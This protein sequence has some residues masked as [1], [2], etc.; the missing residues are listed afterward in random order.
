MIKNRIFQQTKS[1]SSSFF[2]SVFLFLSESR[3]PIFKRFS[4]SDSEDKSP[5]KHQFRQRLTTHIEKIRSDQFRPGFIK[6]NR[7]TRPKPYIASQILGRDLNRVSHTKNRYNKNLYIPFE[8][9]IDPQSKTCLFCN[10]SK[11]R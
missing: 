5:F 4:E 8:F 2:I 9:H 1:G 3:N 7:S 11:I 6:I 10:K